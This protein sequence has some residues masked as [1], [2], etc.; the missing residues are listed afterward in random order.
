[1]ESRVELVSH[2]RTG[3]G[4]DVAEVLAAKLGRLR[5]WFAANEV[6]AAVVGLSGGV[7]SAVTLGVLRSLADE[8]DSPLRRVVALVAPIDGPGATGQALAVDRAASVAESLGAEVWS[9]PLGEAHRATLVALEAGAG[10]AFDGWA[11]GQLLSVVRTPALYGA[12]A[13]LQA[14]GHRSVVVGTTNRDEG[15]YLGFFG[16]ASDGMVDLQ[17]LSDLHKSEVRALAGRLGVPRD[18]IDAEPTGDVWDGRTDAQLIGA[19]YDD[20]ETVLRLRE[21]GRDPAEVARTLG[22]PDEAG[23]LL[24]AV[25]AVERIHRHNAHKY[26]VGSPAVH[27]DVLPR[28]VPGGW[29]DEVLS[30]RSES[31]PPPGV[32]P[33]AWSPA[34][35]LRLARDRGPGAGDVAVGH[36]LA[37]RVTLVPGLLDADE[38]RRLVAAMVATSNPEPV[39]VTGVR[40]GRGIGSVRATAWAPELAGD[41]WHRLRPAVP[42]VRF[43]GPGDATDGHAGPDRTGHRTWRVVGLSPLLRFMRYEPGGRHL[44]HYDAGHDYGDGRR[45][46]LSVVWYLAAGDADTAGDPGDAGPP[47]PAGGATR[48]VRDGQDRLPVWARDHADWDRPTRPDEVALAVAPTPGSALVFDH[49][50]PHDVECWLGPGD[51][52]IVR[53]DVVYEAVPDGRSL[54]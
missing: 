8:A 19:A 48:F 26:R 27:L 38:R 4:F 54:P 47:G 2:L 46:L 33:G 10:L 3:R 14:H 23:A 28:G 32:V 1:M 36:R 43:L 53:A 12:A 11:A 50:L 39:G 5:R 34:P 18:V 41:L 22:D 7:D 16:K 37:P 21:L 45:T 29:G 51:R 42:S 24:S 17:P 40:D 6:D 49:R 52:V 35:T 20:V 15:A 30:P 31:A 9:V 44:V 13:L 25:D